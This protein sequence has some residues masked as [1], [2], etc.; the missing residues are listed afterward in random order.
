[1]A[2]LK[3]RIVSI[4]KIVVD[5]PVTML[6]VNTTEGAIGVLPGHI[7]L[8]TVVRPGLLRYKT[9][10][11]EHRLVASS[12]SLEVKD[13]VATVLVGEALPVE[14]IDVR[15]AEAERE[16]LL[17]VLKQGE[18]SAIELRETREQLATTLA[19]LRARNTR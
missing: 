16:R 10:T 8:L 12:G 19:K 15:K 14:S 4:E 3:L 2:E 9:K 5:E 13:N 18:L 6:N 1:M 17:G 7:P 11:R